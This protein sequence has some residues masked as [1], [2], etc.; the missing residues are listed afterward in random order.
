[1]SQVFGYSLSAEPHENKPCELRE[2]HHPDGCQSTV[3]LSKGLWG[4]GGRV[5]VHKCGNFSDWEHKSLFPPSVR[6]D[7][8]EKSV[9]VQI[10]K[11]L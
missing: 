7:Q 6:D 1:M 3:F 8:D 9:F 4:I 5:Y 10:D 11:W 2:S